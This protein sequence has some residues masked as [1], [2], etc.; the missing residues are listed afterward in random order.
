M[1]ALEQ[2]TIIH[3]A[4]SKPVKAQTNFFGNVAIRNRP[5][6]AG[7]TSKYELLSNIHQISNFATDTKCRVHQDCNDARFSTAMQNRTAISQKLALNKTSK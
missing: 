5:A 4:A 7:T 2:Y 3:N 1:P 6:F